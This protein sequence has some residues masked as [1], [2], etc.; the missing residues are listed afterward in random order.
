MTGIAFAAMVAPSF[1]LLI[2]PPHLVPLKTSEWWS[3]IKALVS[4][5]TQCRPGAFTHKGQL[6]RAAS[7]VEGELTLR[8]LP[9][10]LD[11]VPHSNVL[12]SNAN[13]AR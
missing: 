10:L 7:D 1:V 3:G 13:E 12:S 4:A 5:F 6:P 11:D 9:D 8:D 2:N